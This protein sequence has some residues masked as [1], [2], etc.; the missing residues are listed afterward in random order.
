MVHKPAIYVRKRSYVLMTEWSHFRIIKDHFRYIC[1][2]SFETI[3][4]SLDHD[5]YHW[6]GLG[7]SWIIDVSKRS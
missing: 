4:G 3:K 7:G 6:E 5:P 1:E 2:E